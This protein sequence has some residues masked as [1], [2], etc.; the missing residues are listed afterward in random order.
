MRAG[1]GAIVKAPLTNDQ[2]VSTRMTTTIRQF[3]RLPVIICALALS[4]T[5]VF[6]EPPVIDATF[7]DQP[8]GPL[9]EQLSGTPR[10]LPSLITRETAGDRVDAADAV[11]DFASRVMVLDS[12][13]S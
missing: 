13:P 9:A 12:T 4:G 11:G 8:L 10:R 2:A 3:A 5:M 6:A 1:R 7:D